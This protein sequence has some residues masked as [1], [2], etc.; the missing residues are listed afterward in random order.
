MVAIRGNTYPVRSELRAI[1]G[2]WDPQGKAWMVPETVADR[3][4]QLVDAAPRQAYRPR[5]ATH[6]T[7][8]G[9][10]LSQWAMRHGYRT[11]KEC[12]HGGQS[13]TTSSGEYVLGSDD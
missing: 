7:H 3:A 1:G 10:L 2:R 5:P 8:C 9:E 12:A 4:R 6:C 13:Y 11:C